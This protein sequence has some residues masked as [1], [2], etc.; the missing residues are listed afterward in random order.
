MSSAVM[1]VGIEQDSQK[2]R[3]KVASFVSWFHLKTGTRA[4]MFL[5]YEVFKCVSGEVV[6]Q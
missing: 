3:W 1:K 5:F 2:L 6:G 4:M